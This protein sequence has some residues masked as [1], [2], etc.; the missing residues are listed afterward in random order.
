[1]AG[2]FVPGKDGKDCSEKSG[3]W[4]IGSR[5]N[6]YIWKGDIDE[7]KYPKD[8]CPPRFHSNAQI[9]DFQI[10]TELS[11][12]GKINIDGTGDFGGDVTAP[13]FIGN[14][15][16]NLNGTAS[17]NKGFD[18]PHVKDNRKRIRHICV[19]GP[20]SGIYVRGTLKDDNEII[21]PE[22]WDGL[23]DPE[24]ITVTLTQIG[25]S[26]DLIVEGIECGKVVKIKSGTGVN[27]NCYYEIWAARHINPMDHNEKLHVV[28][29]GDSPQDYPGNNEYYLLGGWDYD[30]RE[31]KWRGVDTES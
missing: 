10:N 23:V 6:D 4:G 26:Q 16:G 9:D 25:Y 19:E 21:L 8:A 28:Y 14:F 24:T 27:I 1:M 2:K 12:Q 20:E 7:D 18:I 13:T 22:Y 29:E 5:S 15:V 30:R 11:G 3:G 17:G 31:T